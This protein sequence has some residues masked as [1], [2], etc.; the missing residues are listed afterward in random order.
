LPIDF[1]KSWG[2]KKW[3]DVEADSARVEKTPPAITERSMC[4]GCNVMAY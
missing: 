1:G 3:A 4:D 2:E